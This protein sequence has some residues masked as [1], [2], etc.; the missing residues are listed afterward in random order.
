MLLYCSDFVPTSFEFAAP[1]A[2]THGQTQS[3]SQS[4]SQVDTSPSKE[5]VIITST[6]L[7]ALQVTVLQFH[8]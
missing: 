4:S 6:T 7:T 3:R 5:K 8:V 2:P 1:T